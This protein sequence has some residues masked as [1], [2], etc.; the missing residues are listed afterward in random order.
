MGQLSHTAQRLFALVLLTLLVPPAEPARSSTWQPLALHVVSSGIVTI[1]DSQLI[2]AGWPAPLPRA[3]VALSRQGQPLPLTDTG[4][5]FTFLGMPNQSRWSGTAVYWLSIGDTPARRGALPTHLPTP[6]AWGPDRHYDRHSA[7]AT[8]DAW[9]A[10]ELRGGA[11]LSARVELPGPLLAGGLLELRM[12]ASGAQREHA[13]AVAINGAAAGSLRWNDAAARVVTQTLTL[14][15]L[16]A[17]SL[18]IDLSL[19]TA[20]DTVLVD[21]LRLPGVLLPA[22]PAPAPMPQ[23]IMPLPAGIA[24]AD[25]LIISER[26]FMGALGPL[27]AAHQ[28]HGRRVATIDVQATYDAFSAGERDPEAIRR[29]IRWARPHAVLLVGAGN[30]AL[31]QQDPARPTFI[32]PYLMRTGRDGEIACDSCYGRLADGPP[33]QQLIPDIPIG[34]FPVSTLAEAQALVNKTVVHLAE[35]A[36]GVW[37]AR[38]VALADNDR[39]P[40]G[41]ADPAG[42]FQQTIEDGLAALP[43]GIAIERLYYAPEQAMQAGALEPDVERLRCRLFRM[44]DGGRPADACAPLADPG[45]ALWIYAGHG[46]PWQWA[47]TSPPAPTPY[48]W[49]LYDADR[50]RNGVRLPIMLAMT[51]LSGDFANPL[52]QSNDE[53]LVLRAGGGVVASLG[54]S[55]EGV[56]SGHQRLL[57]GVLV[58]LYAREGERT[59]GAAHLAGLRALAGSAPE[60]HFAFAIL[61]D[62]LV[63]APFVP[64]AAVALPVAA[65][66]P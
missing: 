6:L 34:R 57:S 27:V 17:G 38:V 55:G 22:R 59:L 24:G 26:S 32:P 41:A 37:R 66:A 44:L 61:G 50:L 30:V 8:G 7:T 1:A 47:S 5:G 25:L 49:Y 63:R 52:L 31:R 54:S 15:A 18:R 20:G 29:A 2:A 53:R 28:A 21:D 23:P 36:G 3:L 62:P 43:Q 11:V 14:P 10:G 42:S 65:V 16:P 35:A 33:E 13:V 51:C 56:N 58:R 39:E 46:S 64:A 12:R 48:L 40:D 19:A 9:W 4:E 60:L 45:A